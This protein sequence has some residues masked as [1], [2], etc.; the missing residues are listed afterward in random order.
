MDKFT[1]LDNA[2]FSPRTTFMIKPGRDHTFRVSYNKAFRA[3]SLVN[4]FLDVTILQSF[5]LGLINPA[6][7]GQQFVFLIQ[8]TGN[9]GLSE[10]SLTAYEIGYTGTFANKYTFGAAFYV[11][12]TT[13]NIICNC[14]PL[15]VDQGDGGV[16]GSTKD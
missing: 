10:E 2:V 6:L 15:W 13:D 5:D 9:P 4:N 8:A 7:A 12:E 14:L 16:V 11:N 1:V 3:P